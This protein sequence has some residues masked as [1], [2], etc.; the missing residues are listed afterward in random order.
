[1]W[2]KI[3][4]NRRRPGQGFSIVE[5]LVALLVVSFL[6]GVIFSI[7]SNSTSLNA[8]TSKR[9]EAGSLAFKKIQDYI[10]RSY[11][12]IPIGNTATNYEV[13]DFSAEAEAL[14][15]KNASAKVF[16]KPESVLPSATSPVTTS[17]SQTITA[18]AAYIAGSEISP[19]GVTDA[20]NI[21][22]NDSRISDNNLT[23]YTYNC[24]SPGPDNKPLPA[25]D[26]GTSQ[27]P[28]NIRITWWSCSYRS[29]NFRIEAKD[30]NPT[31]N[32]SWVSIKNGLS[33]GGAP[34]AADKTQ[35]VDVSSNTTPYRYWRMYVVNGLDN[36]W[37]VVSEFDAFSA[38]V[39][40]DIV[41]QHGSDASSSPGSLTFSDAL[42]EMSENGTSGHQSLGLIFDN[43]NARPGA[44]IDSA[45]LQF[46]SANAQSG[47]VTVKV[48]GEDVDNADPWSGSFA[49]DNAVDTNSADGKIG[50]SAT[51]TWT[52]P[53]WTA[54]QKDTN[55]RVEVTSLLQEI[56]SRS[57]WA[58]HNDVAFAVQ[59]I[60][61]TG[62]RVTQRSTPP[63]LVINWSETVTAPS[64]SDYV[65]ANGDGDVDNPTL[66]RATVEIEY[67][68]FGKRFKIEYET[69]IRKFGISD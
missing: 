13:E 65:D 3:S 39:P 29:D 26:L 23:N 24:N 61:G 53:S 16:I 14:K 42:L 64:S 43:L 36:S 21:N 67:D 22:C 56:L 11:I 20:S 46:T 38:G 33:D 2:W 66:L 48:I 69:F 54:S 37:N 28:N 35:V 18:D 68:A 49:V 52:P 44:T 63:E 6:G 51:N 8:R 30:S 27:A 58:Q 45:Y 62:K 9:A 34:C 5:L 50:T 32:S 57:G 41:E 25:I 59:Y 10:N 17:Y 19:V 15:L 40:G 12:N 60:S 4:S 47:A 55:T 31:S 7:V 1:M